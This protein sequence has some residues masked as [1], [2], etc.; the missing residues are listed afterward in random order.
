MELDITI[1][2]KIL[3]FIKNYKSNIMLL[4]NGDIF[5]IDGYILKI[6]HNSGI[7]LEIAF[8][9]DSLK[10]FLTKGQNIKYFPKENQ[11]TGDFEKIINEEL[12][13]YTDTF[14]FLPSLKYI[15]LINN[16]IYQ[17]NNS[18][19]PSNEPIINLDN[20]EAGYIIR[21]ISSKD[22]AKLI[23]ING[24]LIYIYNG[25]IPLNKSDKAYASYMIRNDNKA[26]L[27]KIDIKKK[28]IEFSEYISVLNLNR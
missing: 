3:N 17:I 7:D 13:K 28:G 4:R 20:I 25:L 24:V 27:L 14:T 19:H 12:C 8:E 10:K 21:N 2:N 23:N 16:F 15:D 11:L 18:F 5:G 9:C 6:G 1:I 22:G 26:F